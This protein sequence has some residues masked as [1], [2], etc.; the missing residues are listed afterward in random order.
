MITLINFGAGNP[1]KHWDNL[2]NSPYFLLTPFIHKILIFFNISE[3][4]KLFTENK[5]QYFFFKKNKKLPYKSNSVNYIH[6]SHVLEHLSV[7]ENDWF[8]KECNRILKKGG[9]VR[10][11]VPNLQNNLNF[12][13]YAFS[14]EKDLLT[15]PQ[16]LKKSRVRAMLEAFHG[17]PSFHKTMFIDKNIENSFKK[18]WK[19]YTNLGY[20]K[21]KINVKVL[22]IVEHEQRTK[23][24]VIF[25]LEKK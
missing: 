7:E 12:N 3:R 2:D 25:E 22:K 15:L 5:Y 19:V 21:S 17:F 8:F 23:N 4:S 11:I 9:I 10:V 18:D 20:L 1:V 13:S 16:E 6:T 14:L 24:A